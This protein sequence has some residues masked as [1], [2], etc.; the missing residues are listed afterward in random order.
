MQ[1]SLLESLT[2]QDCQAVA[3]QPLHLWQRCLHQTPPGTCFVVLMISINIDKL[4][5]TWVLDCKQGQT[6]GKTLLVSTAHL[7]PNPPTSL[8]GHNMLQLPRQGFRQSKLPAKRWHSWHDATM[9]YRLYNP[10]AF[11]VASHAS[12]Q[13]FGAFW[14]PRLRVVVAMSTARL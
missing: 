7:P 2:F 3:M 6:F 5:N 9:L 12:Q 11:Q 8:R 13:M 10:K 14:S 1:R 4:L